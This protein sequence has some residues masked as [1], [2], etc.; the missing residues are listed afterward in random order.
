MLPS[1]SSRKKHQRPQPLRQRSPSSLQ[2]CQTSSHTNRTR[3]GSHATE[4]HCGAPNRDRNHHY[5]AYSNSNSSEQI[6]FLTVSL[7]GAY[8]EQMSPELLLDGWFRV[9]SAVPMGG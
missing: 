3:S 4:P 1:G 8:A 2:L 6:E 7:I 5:S 9:G